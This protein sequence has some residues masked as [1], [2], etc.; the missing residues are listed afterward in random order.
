ML[1]LT[2]APLQIGPFQ[3]IP[4][5]TN[6]AI[7]AAATSG[8]TSFDNA[9]SFDG[10]RHA[11]ARAAPD[12]ANRHQLV[13]T[14]PTATSFGHGPHACPGRYFAANEIKV[15]IAELL[16]KYDLKFADGEG[17]PKNMLLPGGAVFANPQA[18]VLFRARKGLSSQ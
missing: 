14:G 3:R 15:L 10:F 18:K 16:I 12:A 7:S 1:R 8:I 13:T 5:N 17:R 2:T 11:R 4:A 9:D 6:V